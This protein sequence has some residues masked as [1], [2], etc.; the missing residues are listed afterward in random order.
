[1]HD[2]RALYIP[3][4][5]KKKVFIPAESKFNVLKTAPAPWGAENPAR[6]L[7]KQ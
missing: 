5:I 2:P 6:G 7:S 1:M 4:V 3:F